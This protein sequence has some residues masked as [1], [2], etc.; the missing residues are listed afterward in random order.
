[1][2][3]W[4]TIFN[5]YLILPWTVY[6]TIGCIFYI[7]CFYFYIIL[8]NLSILLRML[9]IWYLKWYNSCGLCW[10]IYPIFIYAFNHN[11]Y[12]S[13]INLHIYPNIFLIIY[14]YFI[15]L[16]FLHSNIIVMY[17]ILFQL[18]CIA[19]RLYQYHYFLLW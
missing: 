17:L 6:N 15:F 4:K 7:F 18:C 11:L 8:Y 10:H 2:W 19:H 16:C 9:R 14:F 5:I 1:M 12:L 13:L 3:S